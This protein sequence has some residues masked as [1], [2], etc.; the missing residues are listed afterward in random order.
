MKVIK[1][2][3]AMPANQLYSKENA[4][5]AVSRIAIVSLNQR[6]NNITTFQR[7]IRE[8]RVWSKLKHSNIIPLLGLWDAFAVEAS[9]ARYPVAISPW[10]ANGDLHEYLC[11]NEQVSLK[12]RLSMVSAI[13]TYS[14]NYILLMSS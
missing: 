4:T 9:R 13:L 7:V 1:P 8:M 12:D 5:C 11:D 3:K 14:V 6:Q 2:V 10:M